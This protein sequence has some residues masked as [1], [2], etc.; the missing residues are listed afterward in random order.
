M[1]MNVDTANK[2]ASMF[3]S[4]PLDGARA[5]SA[6]PKS[7]SAAADDVVVVRKEAQSVSSLEDVEIPSFA[8]AKDD[9]LGNLVSA[10]FCAKPPPPPSW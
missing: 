2:A 10:A 6:V 9:R 8:L 7:D 1:E 4:T 5:A 3:S